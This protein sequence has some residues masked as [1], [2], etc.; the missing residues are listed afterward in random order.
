MIVGDDMKAYTNRI[1]WLLG[2]GATLIYM[3]GLSLLISN[4][5][6]D[7]LKIVINTLIGVALMGVSLGVEENFKLKN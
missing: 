3:A 1:K 7:A 5:G 4:V 6:S 2:V